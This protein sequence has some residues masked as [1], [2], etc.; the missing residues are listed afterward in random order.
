MKTYHIVIS[1]VTKDELI[2]ALVL[3]VFIDKEALWSRA[4]ATK[5]PDKVL[6]FN[7][8]DHVD[9]IVEIC[10]SMSVVEE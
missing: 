3:K 5:Q 10:C 4:A 2:K 7:S 8:A 1:L 6:V 9:F